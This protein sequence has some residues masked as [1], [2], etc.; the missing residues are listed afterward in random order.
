MRK[1][2]IVLFVDKNWGSHKKTC[3][4]SCVGRWVGPSVRLFVCASTFEFMG[5]W[6]FSYL[7]GCV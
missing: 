4:N 2:F 1:K 7:Y 6:V 5:E 3:V